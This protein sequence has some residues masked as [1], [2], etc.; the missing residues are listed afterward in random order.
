MLF[1]VSLAAQQEDEPF[2]LPSHL[3]GACLPLPAQKATDHC[4]QRQHL[5]KVEGPGAVCPGGQGP[6]IQILAT[7]P[8]SVTGL[9]GEL[10]MHEEWLSSGPVR[11]GLVGER[12]KVL[13]G[14]LGGLNRMQKPQGVSQVHCQAKVSVIMGCASVV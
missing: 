7:Q 12:A 5:P 14:A 13:T 11:F 4:C 3:Q 10:A 1:S 9:L 8:D 6:A 2:L